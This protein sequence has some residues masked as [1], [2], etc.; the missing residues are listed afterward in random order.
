[1]AFYIHNI[2][3]SFTKEVNSILNVLYTKKIQKINNLPKNTEQVNTGLR[4]GHRYPV[5]FPLISVLAMYY[6]S[7]EISLSSNHFQSP[8]M[9]QGAYYKLSL[10]EH[11]HSDNKFSVTQ[12]FSASSF[13]SFSL[14]LCFYHSGHILYQSTCV[15]HGEFCHRLHNSEFTNQVFELFLQASKLREV[16]ASRWEGLFGTQVYHSRSQSSLHRPC[17][18]G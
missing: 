16:S 8:K 6:T 12:V 18:M 14:Q 17:Q 5:A 9:I 3:L 4:L 2:S 1:M 10:H 11:F 15:I 7:T 13:V